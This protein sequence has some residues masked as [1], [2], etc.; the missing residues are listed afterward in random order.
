VTGSSRTRFFA[1]HD[2]DAV[3]ATRGGDVLLF[4]NDRAVLRLQLHG[5]DQGRH[6][7][8]AER[9]REGLAH[10]RAPRGGGAAR[11][12]DAL[13]TASLARAAQGLGSFRA[14]GV[15]RDE[16]WELVEAPGTAAT[17]RAAA[18]EALASGADPADRTRMRVA[19]ERCAEP[20][21]RSVLTRVAGVEEGE[22]EE[23]AERPDPRRMRREAPREPADR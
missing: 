17:S 20:L 14:P 1:Y 15:T 11:L 4:R 19:A 7:A 12:A 21:A 5:E 9:I 2:I 23:P 18:A 22:E 16:L 6:E 13:G 8:I 10:A 3:Q